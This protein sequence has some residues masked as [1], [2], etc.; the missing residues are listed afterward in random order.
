MSLLLFIILIF[1]ITLLSGF[2]SGIFGG[3]SGLINVP[4]FYLL[5][6]YFYPLNDH[7]M[8]VAIASAVSSGVLVGILAT[9][10][11]HKYKQ[12]CYDTL[13]WSLFSILLG[14]ILGVFLVNVIKSNDLKIVF[15]ILLII[16]ATW[17]WRKTK[18]ALK[19]WQAP[20]ILKTLSAFFAGM[21]TMLSGISVFF[22][23]LLI[24]CGLDI[25]KAIG[26]STI[27]TFFISLVMSIF[28]ISFG[29]HA[30]NLPPFCIGYLNLI[31][32]L[33][34]LIPS[35]IG[36]NIGVKV[37]ALFSHKHLQTIY[38]LM[39]FIIAIVMIV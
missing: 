28:F 23:P 4:G 25:R 29:W 39:M 33:A 13:R 6:H 5:L 26:T 36:V 12:I 24:K 30:S 9:F 8:Q 21:C 3:G 27:I 20:L 16:M 18:K 14:G 1:L 31:I 38:I 34:G 32:F 15:S 11:Q 22:I 17:M 7:L 2:V 19:V 35:L 10:K 37:T